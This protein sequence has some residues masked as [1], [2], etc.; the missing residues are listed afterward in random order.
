MWVFGVDLM[1]T[2]LKQ[3]LISNAIFPP[4]LLVH[5]SVDQEGSFQL[6]KIGLP[7][8]TALCPILVIHVNHTQ[9]QPT[10]KIPGMKVVANKKR[11]HT[12]EILATK[13]QL[14]NRYQV[15]ITHT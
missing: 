13:A 14:R 11:P 3:R 5:Y 6:Q 9:L 10:T 8:S 7:H 15:S 12:P 1:S 4:F 2:I